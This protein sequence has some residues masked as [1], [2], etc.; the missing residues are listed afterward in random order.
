MGLGDAK[1]ALSVGWLLGLWGGI[2][3]ILLSFWI[4]AA[5]ALVLMLVQRALF[6][7]SALGMKS[8]LPFGPFILIG[9]LIAFIFGIDIQTIL[10][11][12]AV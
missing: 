3:A 2:A 7:K 1:L 6:R 11:F 8:E 4:G 9:T 10:L 12:L 5:F